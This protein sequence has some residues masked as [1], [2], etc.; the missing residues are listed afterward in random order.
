MANQLN[1]QPEFPIHAAITTPKGIPCFSQSLL[2]SLS[3]FPAF[4]WMPF[5]G[6]DG[7]MGMDFVGCVCPIYVPKFPLP[8]ITSDLTSSQMTIISFSS[9]NFL[10]ATDFACSLMWEMGQ[11]LC[12][13][14]VFLPDFAVP[15]SFGVCIKHIFCGFIHTN[16]VW[17]G[18]LLYRS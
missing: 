1:S 13:L 12:F 10:P 17:G 5:P 8:T 11:N 2:Q 6:G 18:F 7:W 15:P 16:L 14:V 9:P 4:P 3:C